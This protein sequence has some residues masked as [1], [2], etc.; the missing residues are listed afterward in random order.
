MCLIDLRCTFGTG[1]FLLMNTG[2]GV[3]RSNHGLLTT[4]AYQ[5]GDQSLPVYALEGSVAYSGSVVQ[6]LRDNLKF[7]ES[8]NASEALAASVDDNGGVYFVPAFSGSLKLNDLFL[9]LQC[10]FLTGC[11]RSVCSSLERRCSRTDHRSNRIQHSR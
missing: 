8:V 7:V 1:A 3:I 10:D 6:W 2:H 5:L 11:C 4:L 9:K